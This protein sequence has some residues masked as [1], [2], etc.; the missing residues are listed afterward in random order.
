MGSD[1]S[2]KEV[3]SIDC[4]ASVREAISLMHA[5]KIHHVAVTKD[6]LFFGIFSEREL[7]ENLANF[8]GNLLDQK[9]EG[10]ADTRVNIVSEDVSFGEAVRLIVESPASAIVMIQSGKI[11][12]IITETDLLQVLSG[13]ESKELSLVE[14][15][16]VALAEHPFARKLLGL[17]NDIGL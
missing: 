4:N 8:T 12:G 14:K 13:V 5:N 11:V 15:G 6:D 17:L 1:F 2:K 10:L 9:L 3:V 7:V 16:E